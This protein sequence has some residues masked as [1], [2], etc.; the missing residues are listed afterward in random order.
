MNRKEHGVI[1]ISGCMSQ[2]ELDIPL[3]KLQ[4][5]VGTLVPLH[6]LNW[7]DLL[8]VAVFCFPREETGPL[9]FLD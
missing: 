7:V 3:F 9:L 8:Y 6:W 2:L 5:F 4:C 1:W